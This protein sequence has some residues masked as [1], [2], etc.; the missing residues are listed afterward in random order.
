MIIAFLGSES[1][2]NHRFILA[3]TGFFHRHRVFPLTISQLANWAFSES[4]LTSIHL[5]ASI[6]V[7]GE[8]CFSYCGSL[9]SI[10]FDPA[11]Q[12]QEI[13]RDAFSGVFGNLEH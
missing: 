7:I 9:V 1:Q 5:P 11:S 4:G 10:T 12:L 13:H 2:E 8:S 6:T 3:V